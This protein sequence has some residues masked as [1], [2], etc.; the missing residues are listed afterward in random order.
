M[1]KIV[2]AAVAALAL[3]GCGPI[4]E[5]TDWDVPDDDAVGYDEW[6]PGFY[7]AGRFGGW[8][9]DQDRVLSEDEWRA[10]FD[11][12]FG[13]YDDSRWGRYSDWDR[14]RSGLLSEP[15]FASGVFDSYDLDG[16][17]ALGGAELGAFAQDW[18]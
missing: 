1:L 5:T 15:E 13:L 16:D 10:G 4:A 12:D 2:T 6:V 7:E 9:T 3:T 8:D 18:N 14:D 17:T 11:R